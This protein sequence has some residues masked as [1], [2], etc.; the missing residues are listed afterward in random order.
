MFNTFF[1]KKKLFPNKIQKKFQNLFF[2]GENQFY[3]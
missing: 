1:N 3:S 2:F